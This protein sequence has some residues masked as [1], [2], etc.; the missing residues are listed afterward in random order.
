[1][2]AVMAMTVMCAM[3]VTVATVPMAACRS[4]GGRGCAEGNRGDDGEGYLAKHV[5]SPGEV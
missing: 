4:R 2:V 5:C 3:A 1:M